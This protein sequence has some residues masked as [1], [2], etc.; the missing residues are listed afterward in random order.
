MVKVPRY[1]SGITRK[2]WKKW[3][4][5]YKSFQKARCPLEW[6]F[7]FPSKCPTICGG[8]IPLE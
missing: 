8:Q 7:F 6:A 3:K 5:S 2:K 4:K 1:P